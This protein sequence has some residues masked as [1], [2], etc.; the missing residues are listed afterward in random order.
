MHHR[1]GGCFAKPGNRP[2]ETSTIGYAASLRPEEIL[3]RRE[4]PFSCG[5]DA[6]LR[7]VSAW[8]GLG[9]TRVGFDL[10]VT[11]QQ[12]TK[13]RIQLRSGQMKLPS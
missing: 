8:H 5:D 4:A 7:N 1:L 2:H 6:M 3:E 10:T 12:A 13:L 11:M 9:F